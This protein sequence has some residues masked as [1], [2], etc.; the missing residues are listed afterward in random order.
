MSC[1]AEQAKILVAEAEANNL[2]V[3]AFNSRWARWNTCSLC[4]QDYH[5]VVRCAL[6]WACWKTYVGRSEGEVSEARSYAMTELGNGLHDAEHHEDAL[7]V[8][9]ARLSLERR[10]GVSEESMLVAQS[11]LAN[12]LIMCGQFEKALSLN[13]EIYAKNAELYGRNHGVTLITARNLASC[14]VDTLQQF[15]EARA[16]LRDRIPEAIRTLGTDD[17]IT[18]RLQRMYAQSLY[19]NADASLEDVTAAIATLEDV[20]RRQTRTYGASHPQT[21]STR[22]R[23]A[24]ARAKLERK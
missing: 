10:H 8:R 22:R 2:G 20:D 5:G 24:E 19:G 13:R 4:E 12:S 3:E 7:S 16:F 15:D 17:G 21:E 23:L 18:F 1:L 14:L 9:E 11:N 6:S